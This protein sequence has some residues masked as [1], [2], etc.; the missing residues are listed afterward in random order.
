MCIFILDQFRSF[1]FLHLKKIRLVP[2]RSDEMMSTS[3]EIKGPSLVRLYFTLRYFMLLLPY[4]S[5]LIFSNYLSNQLPNY[6]LTM[7]ADR[8][9]LS[10]MMS[11]Y[12]L[13]GVW[14]GSEMRCA[15]T[16]NVSNCF[17]CGDLFVY[18]FIYSGR[19]K[20]GWKKESKKERKEE[21]KEESPP[22]SVY[23]FY[24]IL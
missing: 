5:P 7:S 11:T 10:R 12:F 3:C 18:L 23:L 21:G 1:S 17:S 6:D 14:C 16:C 8:L 4:V 20:E 19:K 2:I 15:T 9:D 24:A 13:F 22:S